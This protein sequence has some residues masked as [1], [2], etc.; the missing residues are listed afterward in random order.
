MT[1]SKVVLFA[2]VA[3]AVN[4]SAGDWRLREESARQ[5]VSPDLSYA[6]RTAVRPSDGKTIAAHLA[7]FR[8]PAFRLEVVDLGAGAESAYPTLA[9]AM[10][11]EGCAAGVNGGFFHPDLRPLGLVVSRGSRINRLETARLLS[12]V[13]YSDGRGI[14]LVRRGRFRDAPDITALLQS[15]PY[16]VEGG[17]TVRGLSASDPR[18]RTFIATD[19]R[20]HWV[21]GA[22]LGPITL[23]ELGQCLA[24]PAAL[25]PW[26]VDRAL[27]LDGGSSTGFYFAPS[28]GHPGATLNP[29][30]RVRTL[31]GITPR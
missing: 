11:A 14:H 4:A 12:G 31:L 26:S 27:N 19:W 17:R 16:L 28:V 10:R 15:G 5:D 13:V 29:L 20:G 21:L 1:L 23:A 2:M 30:K 24:S 6:K 3:I 25:T 7:F 18:R 9:E 22:T 8:S